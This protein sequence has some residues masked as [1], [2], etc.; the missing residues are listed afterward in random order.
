MEDV[1]SPI[2]KEKNLEVISTVIDAT[3]T[4]ERPTTGFNRPTV[5]FV[6]WVGI[7]LVI[8]ALATLDLVQEGFED[9]WLF[10]LSGV[11]LLWFIVRDWFL[12]EGGAFIRRNDDLPFLGVTVFVLAVTL[13]VLVEQFVI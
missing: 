1:S 10:L 13:W 7:V 4:G 2:F 9:A 6:V 3:H 5:L 8:T 12:H 11:M